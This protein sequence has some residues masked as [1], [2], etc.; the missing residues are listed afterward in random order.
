M[1]I[2]FLID[3]QHMVGSCISCLGWDWPLQMSHTSGNDIHHSGIEAIRL[4]YRKV[5]A[6][7][8]HTDSDMSHRYVPPMRLPS[9][10]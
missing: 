7:A 10:L 8:V 6:L 4:F 1:L 2:P 5:L 3:H 9:T